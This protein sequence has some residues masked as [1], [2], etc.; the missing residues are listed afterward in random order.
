M[1]FKPGQSGNPH[2]RTPKSVIL[3]D[4]VGSKTQQGRTIIRGILDIAQHGESEN[5]RL[6][7]W[8]ELGNR[9][10]GKPVTT[11]IIQANVTHEDSP[12]ASLTLAE[13]EAVVRTLREREASLAVEGQVI[14][15]LPAPEPP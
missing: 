6:A 12:L 8:T 2:G 10:W 11:A 7:A 1:P 14:E 4:Y 13:L 15:A 5:V 9:Y 3:A